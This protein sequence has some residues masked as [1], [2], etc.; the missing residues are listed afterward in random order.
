MNLFWQHY[1]ENKKPTFLAFI[2]EQV[3]DAILESSKTN[4]DLSKTA[5]PTFTASLKF[6]WGGFFKTVRKKEERSEDKQR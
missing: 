2:P 3:Y 6:P 5:K 1:L 4:H